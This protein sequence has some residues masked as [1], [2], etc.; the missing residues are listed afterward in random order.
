MFV[1]K[2]KSNNDNKNQ[3]KNNNYDSYRQ[4]KDDEMTGHMGL[5]KF[6]G[7]FGRKDPLESPLCKWGD[8]IKVNLNGVGCEGVDKIQLA[9]NRD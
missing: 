5:K 3:N 6:G 1:A 4:N 2:I 8:T 9:R 7:N